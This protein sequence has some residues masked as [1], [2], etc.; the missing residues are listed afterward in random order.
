MSGALGCGCPL[1]KGRRIYKPEITIRGRTNQ[2]VLTQQWGQKHIAIRFRISNW[3]VEPNNQSAFRSLRN[4]FKEITAS[5]MV[6]EH[7]CHSL[8]TAIQFLL[9]AGVVTSAWISSPGIAAE[10]SSLSRVTKITYVALIKLLLPLRNALVITDNE[11]RLH[12]RWTIPKESAAHFPTSR[13]FRNNI[14][15]TIIQR[16]THDI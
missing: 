13:S 9:S 1:N 8:D 6:C 2:L 16:T 12:T 7:T 5:D 4:Y 14:T 15:F 3:T 10:M 11:S